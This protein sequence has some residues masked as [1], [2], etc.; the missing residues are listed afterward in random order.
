MFEYSAR[1]DLLAGRTILVTGA[2][3]GIG[4]GKSSKLVWDDSTEDEDCEQWIRARFA[5][6]STWTA[7]QL[8]Q[9]AL[10]TTNQG[11]EGN[12]SLA[13][14]G[15]NDTIVSFSNTAVLI[16]GGSGN[17]HITGND[18]AETLAQGQG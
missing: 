10:A 18:L 1:P 7:N 9:L 5:D 4:K 6:G 2:G 12:D 8:T 14:R 11:T 13:G 17:D 15:G 3:R 16:D